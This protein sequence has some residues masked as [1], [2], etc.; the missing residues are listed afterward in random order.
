IRRWRPPKFE[1]PKWETPAIAITKEDLLKKLEMSRA[2]Q[3]ERQKVWRAKEGKLANRVRELAREWYE[4]E[5]S[6]GNQLYDVVEGVPFQKDEEEKEQQETHLG[7]RIDKVV[8]TAKKKFDPFWNTKNL[9]FD[10]WIVAI[11]I[12]LILLVFLLAR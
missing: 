1:P 7:D 12:A 8:G 10:T 4:K 11:V 3:R 9:G 2:K 6:L 5:R